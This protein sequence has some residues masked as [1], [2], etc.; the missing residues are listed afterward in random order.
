MALEGYRIAVVGDK[1]NIPLFRSSGLT[2]V[3]A[4]TQ[5]DAIR[6]VL[7]L[8]NRADVGLIIVL[9]HII[10]DEDEFRRMIKDV[11]KPV[12]VLPTKWARAEPINVDKL[13]AKALGLG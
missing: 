9:K 13:L 5:T 3:E 1:Y 12:L 6:R 7:E 11:E 2:V 10:G 4:Y 8:N